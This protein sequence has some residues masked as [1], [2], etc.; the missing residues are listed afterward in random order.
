MFL[1]MF[2]DGF[3]TFAWRLPGMCPARSAAKSIF[4]QSITMLYHQTSL[5]PLAQEP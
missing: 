3:G 4:Q 1:V 2:F 5:P